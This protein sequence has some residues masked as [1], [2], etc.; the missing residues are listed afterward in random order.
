M[1]G[2]RLVI[3]SAAL[4][5]AAGIAAGVTQTLEE[6]VSPAPAESPGPV[7][8]LAKSDRLP[9]TPAVTVKDRWYQESPPERSDELLVEHK[10][11]ISP[12]LPRSP[13]IATRHV[14]PV[15]GDRGRR[16]YRHHTYWRCR[17]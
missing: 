15:C 10:A 13:P 2:P 17:R 8:V 16:W 6:T 1:P 9:V 5:A 14:D 4:L 11:A 7:L 12:D 3:A